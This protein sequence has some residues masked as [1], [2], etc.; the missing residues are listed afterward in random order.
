LSRSEREMSFP[1]TVAMTSGAGACLQAVKAINRIVLES[2]SAS[3]LQRL[4]EEPSTCNLESPREPAVSPVLQ[5]NSRKPAGSSR[6]GLLVHALARARAKKQP[7]VIFPLRQ[8]ARAVQTAAEVQL[9]R[10]EAPGQ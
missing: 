5:D 3:G 1:F 9:R 10:R 2:A 7:D 4:K 8:V 6:S